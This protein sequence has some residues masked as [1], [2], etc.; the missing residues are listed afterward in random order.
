MQSVPPESRG[1][2]HCTGGHQSQLMFPRC[3]LAKKWQGKEQ[4]GGRQFGQ[5]AERQDQRGKQPS[6]AP[7]SLQ[8]P[9]Q[10]FDAHQ[11]KGT[12][13]RIWHGFPPKRKPHGHRQHQRRHGRQSLGVPSGQDQKK[14]PQSAHHHHQVDESRMPMGVSKPLAHRAVHPRKQGELHADF[15][16]R[17]WPFVNPWMQDVAIAAG[18]VS[19]N[20]E[21]GRLS[22]AVSSFQWRR[23]DVDQAHCKAQRQKPQQGV[24]PFHRPKM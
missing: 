10:R 6:H 12:T 5:H 7:T 8:C 17:L 19:G 11:D 3:S 23:R 15:T 13:E 1:D 2:H 9:E 16:R 20:H 24:P 18:E 4:D 14:A 22:P 21:P